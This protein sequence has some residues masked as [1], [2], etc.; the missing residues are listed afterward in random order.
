MKNFFGGVLLQEESYRAFLDRSPADN[1]LDPEVATMKHLAAAEL[2]PTSEQFVNILQSYGVD[3]AVEVAEKFNLADPGSPILPGPTFTRF[4]YQ[5]LFQGAID[6]AVR[7]F[8]MGVRAHPSSAN[9][10]GQL[11]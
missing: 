9:S 5:F 10:L 1:G 7:I 4:G 11:R 8:E 6:D 2:P 3:R